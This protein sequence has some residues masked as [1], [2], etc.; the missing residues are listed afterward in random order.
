MP[1]SRF[2]REPLWTIES[3]DGTRLFY[4]A[5]TLDGILNAA[6]CIRDD[7]PGEEFIVRRAGAY[8]AS[9]TLLAQEG[10]MV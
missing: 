5:E 10:L 8:D 2:D 1:V 7:F 6:A 9:A 3:P 4:S